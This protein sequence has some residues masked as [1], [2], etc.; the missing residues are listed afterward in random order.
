[1][2][3]H[4][5]IDTSSVYKVTN[6]GIGNRG[7]HV[8]PIHV[9]P[10]PATDMIHI[11]SPLS[12]NTIFIS[13]EGRVVLDGGNTKMISLKKLANGFY[14]MRIVDDEGRLLKVEKVLKQKDSK[15]GTSS[16]NELQ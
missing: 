1:S 9:Y 16:F 4:G 3:E 13:L 11:Q 14:F 15:R 6:V 2:N 10:N 12:I 5:C 8:E 7:I